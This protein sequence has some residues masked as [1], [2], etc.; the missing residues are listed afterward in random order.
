MLPVMLPCWRATTMPCAYKAPHGAQHALASHLQTEIINSGM[1]FGV[2][3]PA[4]TVNTYSTFSS[5]DGLTLNGAYV[6]G[7]ANMVMASGRDSA[8][9]FFK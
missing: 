4:R 8:V 7:N 9:S 2:Q 6:D 3:V 5:V 1:A